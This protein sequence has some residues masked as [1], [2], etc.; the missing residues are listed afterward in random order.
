MERAGKDEKSCD[1]IRDCCE[2]SKT[3]KQLEQPNNL[4]L[5][6]S[7]SPAPPRLCVRL[8]ILTTSHKT[9]PK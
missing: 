4:P 3:T 1:V 7:A 8:L 5:N 2:S 9:R 6:C